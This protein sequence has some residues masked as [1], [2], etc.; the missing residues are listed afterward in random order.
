MTVSFDF[1]GKTLLL[2][3][4][5]GGIGREITTLFYDAGANLVLLDMDDA[6]LKDIA[7]GHDPAGER[8]AIMKMDSSSV[9]DIDAALALAKDRFGGVD[10]LMPA[11]GIYPEQLVESMTDEQ[12]RQVMT[13]NLDGVFFLIKRALPVMRDGGAIVNFASLAGHRGSYGHS[14]YAATKAAIISLTKTLTLE[15]GPRIRVNAISPG[16]IETRMTGDLLR[17]RG[18]QLVSSTP[19]GRNGQASEVATVSAFLCSPAAS[20]VAGEVIHVNGG[21]FMAG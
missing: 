11:A 7:A 3:G 9:A 14:H 17:T 4:A 18:E 13:I 1:T 19:L 6:A 5:A 2:T 21:L 10:Y 16:I 15:L 20:F 8:I 12:W